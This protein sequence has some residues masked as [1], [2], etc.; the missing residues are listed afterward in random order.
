MHYKCLSAAVYALRQLGYIRRW[1]T[2]KDM[3][4]WLT[5]HL[6]YDYIAKNNAYQ[7]SRAWNEH[8]RFAPAIRDE[9]NRL[10]ELGIHSITKSDNDI[11]DDKTSL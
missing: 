1:L 9:V 11:T 6:S 3:L 8:G 7:F 4:R 5:D 2:K 10:A